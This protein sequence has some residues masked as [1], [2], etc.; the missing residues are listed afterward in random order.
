QVCGLYAGKRIDAVADNV[1]QL[2]SR[3]NSTWGGSLADMVRSRR[4]IEIILDENLADNA[5]V[6]GA[7]LVD[8]L[9]ALARAEGGF[10]NV[11]GIGSLCAFTLESTAARDAL[12]KRLFDGQLMALKSGPKAI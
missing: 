6:Q 2:P 10:T 9:R 4:L 8:G 5:R 11:R 1:F 7:R 3:I 12:L